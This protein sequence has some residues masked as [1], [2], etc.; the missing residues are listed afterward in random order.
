M[1]RY[2]VQLGYQKFLKGYEL[3][4]FSKTISKYSKKFID[5]AKQ[6]ATD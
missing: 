2:L 5:H 4:S 6:F 1:T 3:L